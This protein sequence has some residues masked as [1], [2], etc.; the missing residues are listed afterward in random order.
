MTAGGWSQKTKDVLEAALPALSLA[1]R[2]LTRYKYRE[3]HEWK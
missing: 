3:K 1:L 2:C